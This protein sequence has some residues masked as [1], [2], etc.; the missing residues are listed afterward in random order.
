MTALRATQ[1]IDLFAHQRL[2]HAKTDADA[3]G[4]QTLLRC[5]DQIAE[6]FLHTR[7]ELL[8]RGRDLGGRYGVQAVLLSSSRSANS[9]SSL[10]FTSARCQQQRTKA[11][12]P[13]PQFLPPTGHPRISGLT[14]LASA[15]CPLLKAGAER[16]GIAMGPMTDHRRQTPSAELVD[17]VQRKALFLPMTDILGK[18]G[19]AKSI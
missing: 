6:R 5:P 4:K 17:H 10:D 11:G 8:S 13:P 16:G 2:Q 12:E 9:G 1:L 19:L 15:D 7:R 3:E 18:L 14:P